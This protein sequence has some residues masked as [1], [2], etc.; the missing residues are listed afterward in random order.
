MNTKVTK[1]T[2]KKATV[3]KL[4]GLPVDALVENLL[5]D[6][7]VDHQISMIYGFLGKVQENDTQRVY[8]DPL[9]KSYIDINI[10]DIV[11]YKK[12]TTRFD[13]LEGTIIWLRDAYKAFY[14]QAATDYGHYFQGNIVNK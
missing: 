7:K 2:S 8:F 10:N 9:L 6:D 11:H 3:K 4:T 14:P 5:I 12:L 13:P 1:K